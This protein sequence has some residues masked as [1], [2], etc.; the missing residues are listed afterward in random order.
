[1][2][3]VRLPQLRHTEIWARRKMAPDP[4][5]LELIFLV[6]RN[7]LGAEFA[8]DGFHAVIL[9][10]EVGEALAQP[11]IQLFGP[12]DLPNIVRRGSLRVEVEQFLDVALARKKPLQRLCAVLALHHRL[13]AGEEHR[14]FHPALP[15]PDFAAGVLE[16][17]EADEP[18]HIGIE[19][20][21]SLTS[22]RQIERAIEQSPGL[23]TIGDKANLARDLGFF[24]IIEQGQII[25]SLT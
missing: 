17:I 20:R 21:R 4:E 24:L 2:E 6:Q 5:A 19:R 14:V 10:Q 25:A 7:N 22:C 12:D 15:D 16:S 13:V 3:T 8:D 1:M 23:P 9:Q 11:R 18:A